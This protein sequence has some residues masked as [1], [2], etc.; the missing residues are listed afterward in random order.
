[1]DVFLDWHSGTADELGEA[2]RN[3]SDEDLELT[4]IT[5]RGAKVWPGGMPETFC[6]DH[7]RCRFMAPKRG[8]I[9]SHSQVIALLE[10][11]DEA[12]FDFIKTENLYNFDGKVSYSAVQGE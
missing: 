4:M 5:N 2:F 11:I 10:R 12:G 8:A 3:V 1:V 7:W 6:T 9:I